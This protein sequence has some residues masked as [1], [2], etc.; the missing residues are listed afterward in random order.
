LVKQSQRGFVLSTGRE[1]YS[2]TSSLS[3]DDDGDEIYYGHDG[4]VDEWRE[5]GSQPP[6]T[7]EERREIAEYMI[8][9]WQRWAAR[10]DK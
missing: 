4:T 2:C 8:A 10:T 5:Y 1:F 7:V 3:V 6:L 9:R